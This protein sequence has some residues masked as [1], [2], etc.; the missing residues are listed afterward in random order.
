MNSLDVVAVL[1]GEGVPAVGLE[2]LGAIFSEAEIGGAGKGNAV[3]VV[4]V[5]QFAQFEMAGETRRFSGN[6]FHQ[7][8]IAD[9]G[10]GK[11]IDDLE[12]RPIVARRDRKSTRLNSSHPSIS[13]AVFCLKKKKTPDVYGL[14][15]P[16]L[17]LVP[18]EQLYP[19]LAGLGHLRA[20]V[21]PL[22]PFD[23][24]PL[25]LAPHTL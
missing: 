17:D 22:D 5:D 20:A 9:D 6:T 10:I 24:L 16:V 3:I 15:V 11:V 21:R 12:S 19:D 23:P 18:A 14:Y 8:A 7:I 4:E 1:Q 13:Y 2:A 25:Y